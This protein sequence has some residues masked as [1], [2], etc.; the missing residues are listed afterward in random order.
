MKDVR[1]TSFEF[2]NDEQPACFS[3]TDPMW[4]RRILK[5]AKKYPDDVKVVDYKEKESICVHVPKE[6]FK[7]SP[8]RS[9][10]MTEEQRAAASEM[11]KKMQEAKR[12]K[13]EAESGENEGWL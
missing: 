9:K 1:E 8:P 7:V 2:C 12:A 11:A 5:L 4:I 3:S 13:A 6:W 10:N